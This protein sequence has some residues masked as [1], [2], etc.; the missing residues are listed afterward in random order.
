MSIINV[1]SKLFGISYLGQQSLGSNP[2]SLSVYI[3]IYDNLILTT[4]GR[5]DLNLSVSIGNTMR[6]VLRCTRAH[7]RCALNPSS[8]VFLQ[9]MEVPFELEIIIVCR[10]FMPSFC[11]Y[12]CKWKEVWCL[13]SSHCRTR[14]SL[15]RDSNT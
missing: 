8:S 1:L 4:M 6:C 15:R 9:R 13:V 11:V 10:K 14:M 5:G 2:G 3:Y 7:T 12:R